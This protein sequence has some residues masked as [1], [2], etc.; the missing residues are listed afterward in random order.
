MLA[1]PGGTAEPHTDFRAGE[2]L[3]AL[4][5]Y[6]FHLYLP[7]WGDKMAFALATCSMLQ[8]Y[9]REDLVWSLSSTTMATAA[10]S[11]ATPH[12]WAAAGNSCSGFL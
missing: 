8:R 11:V 10:S 9:G 5:L 7:T 6:C 2:T 12:W 4:Q 1:V 3:Q